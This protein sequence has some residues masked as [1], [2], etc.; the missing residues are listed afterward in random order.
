MAPMLRDPYWNY[1]D[2]GIAN[3]KAYVD[4]SGFHVKYPGVSLDLSTYAE[5]SQTI[6]T[7]F[8]EEVDMV[9][10]ATS[11]YKC[12]LASKWDTPT[13]TWNKFTK[14]QKLAIIVPQELSVEER[15]L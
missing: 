8:L 7:I 14:S 13:P 5:E 6:I 10:G 9:A 4:G 12:I 3:D 2:F 11:M 1:E 15:K